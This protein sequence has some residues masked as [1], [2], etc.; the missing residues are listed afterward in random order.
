M[1][2][3]EKAWLVFCFLSCVPCCWLRLF[4]ASCTPLIYRFILAAFLSFLQGPRTCYR[5]HPRSVSVVV[6]CAQPLPLSLVKLCCAAEGHGP[7]TLVVRLPALPLGFHAS[8]ALI[9]NGRERS[10]CWRPQR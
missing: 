8:L 5:I 2:P 1:L 9:Y 3:F 7:R 10:A 4:L 6:L